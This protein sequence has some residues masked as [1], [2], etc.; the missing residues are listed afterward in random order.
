MN[1]DD[2]EK[3]IKLAIKAVLENNNDITKTGGSLH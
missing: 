3:A 1:L 2:I